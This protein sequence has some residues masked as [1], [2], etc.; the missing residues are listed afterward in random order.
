MPYTL[1][2]SSTASFVLSEHEVETLLGRA[3][4]RN[5]ADDVTGLL[6]YLRYGPARAGFVQ[7]LEGERDAVEQTYARIQRDELHTDLTVSERA[8]TPRR[9]Y[10]AWSMRFARLDESDLREILAESAVHAGNPLADPAAARRV[11]AA[12]E[13]D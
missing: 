12:A 6:V 7:V 1:T 3:R 9:R 10:A 8:V 11:L 2:Y 5:A 13:P 4:A